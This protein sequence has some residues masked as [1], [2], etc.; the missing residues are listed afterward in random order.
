MKQI[1]NNQ[2]SEVLPYQYEPI[3]MENT[4]TGDEK[5][6]YECNGVS[7]LELKSYKTVKRFCHLTNMTPTDENGVSI[8]FEHFIFN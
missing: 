2:M 3:P 8:I 4:S 5:S 1:H 6:D 7:S